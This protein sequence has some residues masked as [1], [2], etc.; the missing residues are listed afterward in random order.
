MRIAKTFGKRSTADDRELE[1]KIKYFLAFEGEETEPQYF[2]GVLQYKNVI[3]INALVEIVPLNRH[4]EE[5]TWS[6]PCKFIGP[7][8]ESMKEYTSGKISIKSLISHSI[9]HMINSS[10]CN[11]KDDASRRISD[12]LHAKILEH[13]YNC[14]ETPDNIEPFLS[15]ICNC[16]HEMYP[17]EFVETSI[18]NLQ[19]YINEQ[20]VFYNSDIDKV[21]L[22]IDRD[23]QNFKP[24]QYDTLLAACDKK[25]FS[26][27][28]SNP[29]FEIWLLMHY[30]DILDY[31]RTTLY[32]NQKTSRSKGSKKFLEVELR[33][34]L[35]GFKKSYIPFHELVDKVDT[36]ILNEKHF[37]ED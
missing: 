22:I 32:E 12:R 31:D 19:K 6:H 33:K 35:P 10:I 37:C 15:I 36:A 13:G 17:T 18:D 34:L 8:I 27:H 29:C 24:D 3:G 21:C 25:G 9:D 23:V 4:F 1:T 28:V 11:S 7:L 14:E 20:A 5:R 16:L 30:P 2:S 26:L